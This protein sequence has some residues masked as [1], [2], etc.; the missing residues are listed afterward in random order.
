MVLALSPKVPA[1]AL[2]DGLKDP[3][4]DNI[5]TSLFVIDFYER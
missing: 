4:G 3:D 5:Y 2:S 1:L